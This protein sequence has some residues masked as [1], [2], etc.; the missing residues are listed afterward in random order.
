MLKTK[1]DASNSAKEKTTKDKI[2]IEDRKVKALLK[3]IKED[4]IA[5]E[6][7]ENEMSKVNIE[8]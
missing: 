1:E 3:S 6:Q 4:E 7:K 8:Y 5:L 2:Q